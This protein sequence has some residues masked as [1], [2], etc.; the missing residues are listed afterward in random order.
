MKQY[1]RK[2]ALAVLGATILA[3][4]AYV[5][6]TRA[7]ARMAQG[8][9]LAQLEV[10]IANPD[11]NLETWML[12]AERLLE[13]GQ[14]GHAAAAF[15]RVL[16]EDPCSQTANLQCAVA[17][18]RTGDAD[19]YFDFLTRLLPIEPR[20]TL[21][22]LGRPISRPFLAEARFDKLLHRAQAQSMD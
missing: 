16:E 9:T 14:F 21:D 3:A 7:D 17:L 2:P 20:L 13:E 22:I 10:A 11:A 4:G 18:A 19:Q 6:T 12:Y 1:S 15:E 8:P 5:W